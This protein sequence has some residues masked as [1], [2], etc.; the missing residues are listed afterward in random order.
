MLDLQTPSIFMYQ[1]AKFER[2]ISALP[3]SLNN[4]KNRTV[5]V[6]LNNMFKTKY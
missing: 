3:L 1:L 4:F 5:A 6:E 2:R